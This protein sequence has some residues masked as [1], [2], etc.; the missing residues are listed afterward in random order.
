MGL[1]LR[2]E[3]AIQ[4]CAR[5]GTPHMKTF[6]KLAVA[7][8]VIAG[9][10]QTPSAA[11]FGR[12]RA[13]TAEDA[14]IAKGIGVT[15]VDYIYANSSAFRTAVQQRQTTY[16]AQIDAANQRREQLVAQL[17]PLVEKYNRDRAA[18]NADQ[19]AL[20]RQ[21]EQINQLQNSGNQAINQLLAP[22]RQSEMYVK[23]QIE[24]KLGAALQTAMI[25][26]RIS[27]VLKASEVQ[28]MNGAYNLNPA[29]IAELNALIPSVDIVP[30]AGWQ[31]RAV[32][33]AQAAQ[34]PQAAP[35]R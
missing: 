15:N 20:A 5:E 34:Q 25:K 13:P 35:P 28:A 12:N 4:P 17:R 7:A 32:R 27:L 21:M 33:E 18:P 3:R 24:A 19:A 31:P 6:A 10:A 29:V 16:K 9:T 8:L 1:Y 26:N 14:V 22:V 30:P 11:Q 23:E 2:A